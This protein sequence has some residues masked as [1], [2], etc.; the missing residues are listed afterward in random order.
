MLDKISVWSIWP[1]K[2]NHYLI[3]KNRIKLH[4]IKPVNKIR[5]IRQIKVQIKHYNIIRWH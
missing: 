5:F 4:Y 2:V 1:E 3:I